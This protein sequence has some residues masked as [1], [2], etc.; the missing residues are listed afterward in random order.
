MTTIKS[1]DC[2][3]VIEHGRVVEY[4]SHDVLLQRRGSYF[5]LWNNSAVK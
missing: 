1:A 4:G 3:F 2:I 5:S